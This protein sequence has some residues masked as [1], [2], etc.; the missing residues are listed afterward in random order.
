[1]QGFSPPGLPGFT[2]YKGDKGRAGLPGVFKTTSTRIRV[3]LKTQLFLCV[4]TFHPHIN[5]VLDH[6][7]GDF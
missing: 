1:M 6:Y 7:G 2:G 4:L 5:S 3:F